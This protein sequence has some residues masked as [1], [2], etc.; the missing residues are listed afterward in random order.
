MTAEAPSRPPSPLSRFAQRF[1][2]TYKERVSPG[3]RSNCRFEPTCSEY[4]LEAYRR[5][6]FVRATAKTSWRL[7]RCNPLNKGGKI[8]P[9]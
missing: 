1:I 3:L 9:P 7:L 6:G 2:T 4:G 8:D 5:Y